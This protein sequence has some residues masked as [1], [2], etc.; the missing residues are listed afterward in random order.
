MELRTDLLRFLDSGKQAARLVQ[1][2]V[3]PGG[4]RCGGGSCPRG[5]AAH[6]D[7]LFCGEAVD[8]H[9]PRHLELVC[10][11]DSGHVYP[12]HPGVLPVVAR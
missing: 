4:K 2:S 6:G 12:G 5:M 9:S 7:G 3:R 8:V 10:E 1:G 11:C